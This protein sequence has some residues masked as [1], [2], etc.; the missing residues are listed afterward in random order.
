MRKIAA[1]LVLIVVA[2]IIY[3]L[4]RGGGTNA[5]AK[6][7][8]VHLCSSSQQEAA[9]VAAKDAP[10]AP[11]PS[12]SGSITLPNGL[13]R[14]TNGP[15]FAQNDP[16][17]GAEEYD[18]GNDQDVG[19]GT[20]IAQC[21]C[22]MTSVATVLSLFNVMTDPHGNALN[23][24]TLNAAFNEGAQ[25]TS[26]GWV[27]AGYSYGNV[28]WTAADS[29][30]AAAAA[31][32]QGKTVRFEGWGTASDSEIR[33]QLQQGLPVILEVPG[34]YIAAV[35][36]QGDQILI[37]D[38]Y[39]ANRTT[40]NAYAG[41][42]KSSRKYA[43]SDDLGSMMITVPSNMRVLVTDKDGKQVGTLSGKTP[44]D[45]Q[46]QA[47]QDAGQY[48]F[49]EAWRDPTC[50]ERPPKDGQGT[51]SVFIPHPDGE[52][53]IVVVNPDGGDTAGVV[54]VTEPD[55][56]DHMTTHEGGDRIEFDV[57]YGPFTSSGNPNPNGSPTPPPATVTGTVT[58]GTETPTITPTTAVTAAVGRH[59]GSPDGHT[60][61]A[62][63]HRHQ[64]RRRR[65]PSPKS[66]RSR[67]RLPNTPITPT[68]V[69]AMSVAPLTA[70]HEPGR[71]ERELRHPDQLD[72]ERRPEGDHH[73]AA[74]TARPSPPARRYPAASTTS[75][76]S[77]VRHTYILQATNSDGVMT[78]SPPL[79]VTPV[80]RPATTPFV[81]ARTPVTA[82][83]R[84]N[85]HSLAVPGQRPGHSQ[86][87][88]VPFG[89]DRGDGFRQCK[90]V[91]RRRPGLRSTHL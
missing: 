91:L 53:H 38:P 19:C 41:L 3:L 4:L 78:Q 7:D 10:P 28:N 48:H 2:V 50:T 66:R 52:Y 30:S 35:G 79:T 75:I 87:R 36:L 15:L 90:R 51:N 42:V 59:A 55:G 27:S 31:K 23:P 45:A 83:C 46:S 9:T 24:S 18:H 37:D 54:H 74:R 13:T 21:G 61:A 43:P 33:A 16:A 60:G 86:D 14:G 49:E 69:P 34:H 8:G 80:V 26:S 20:T 6:Y 81:R 71:P 12:E 73:T 65:R 77:R 85:Q 22:A 76:L 32:G 70:E 62:D 63:R 72:G 84:G 56:T 25:L 57:E 67:R 68:A 39:Y 1:V 82:I 89:Y 64:L 11:T 47:A 88:E 29:I 40:L 17:W 58:P 44:A 5:E